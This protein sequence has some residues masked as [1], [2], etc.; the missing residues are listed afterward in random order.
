MQLTIILTWALIFICISTSIL[1]SILTPIVLLLCPHPACIPLLSS[2]CFC[3]L[4]PLW[5]SK[6]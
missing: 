3:S 4:A 6:Y 2:Y 1:A 5:I